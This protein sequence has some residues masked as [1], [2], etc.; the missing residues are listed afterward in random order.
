M[1]TIQIKNNDD[2]R[3]ALIRAEEIWDTEN[4]EELAELER[5]IILISD[6]EDRML[7]EE[8]T[9]QPEIEVEL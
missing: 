3:L 5:L 2:L 4:I 7:F 1:K 9:S 6:Y 8:R